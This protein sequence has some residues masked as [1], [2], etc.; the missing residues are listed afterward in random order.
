MPL[1]VFFRRAFA[2][3]AALLLALPAV[4]AEAPGPAGPRT[5]DAAT[6]LDYQEYLIPFTLD[7]HGPMLETRLVYPRGKGPWPLAVVT[8]GSPSDAADRRTRR[9]YPDAAR[10]FAAKGFLVAVVTRRGYGHSG[11]AWAEGAGLCSD[12][13]YLAAGEATADDIVAAVRYLTHQ[14]FVD[15]WRVVLVGQAAGGW[16][17]L[18]A[19]ARN[20]EGVVA[21]INLAG[22][23]GTRYEGLVCRSDH[24]IEAAAEWGRRDH[25]P[26]LWLYAENDTAIKPT[27]AAKMFDA[28]AKA[29]A[30]RAEF[31]G[32]FQG[33]FQLVGPTHGI[34]GHRL[35]AAGPATW[36]P[37][38]EHFLERFPGLLP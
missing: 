23:R 35:L 37:A 6:H 2:L 15:P 19:A 20:P 9:L 33:E 13:D 34:D 36:G 24:L 11:G 5:T 31:H 3:A 16:G 7:G 25:A 17:A 27:L 4:A 22:G 29:G 1:A 10:W 12:P 28:Y 26:T 8:H 32:G 21:A 18:A 14:K 30:G 38:V